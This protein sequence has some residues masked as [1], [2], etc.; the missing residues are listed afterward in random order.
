VNPA[1]QND[2]PDSLALAASRAR[3][4]LVRTALRPF[5]TGSDLSRR[6][7]PWM[8]ARSPDGEG[9]LVW[10]TACCHGDEVGGIVVIQEIFRA[11]RARP[12]KR[13]T[14]RAFPLMNPIGFDQCSRLLPASGED[15]NRSFP[16]DP[17]GTLG[18]R[19]AHFLFGE[20]SRPLPALVLD[21]HNDWIRSVPYSVIDAPCETA[22]SSARETAISA[23]SETDAIAGSLTFSLLSRGIPA[24]TLELGE[25]H[26]VNEQNVALAAGGIWAALEAHGMVSPSE[27]PPFPKPQPPPVPSG[28]PLRYTNRPLATKSGIAR[29]LCHPGQL[30]AAGA[31]LVRVVNAFGRKQEVLHAPAEALVLGHADSSV[32]FP[33]TSLVALAVA[34]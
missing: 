10:I 24:V 11:L 9:P 34:G 7:I 17:T 27:A 2:A 12:L 28:H 16:G 5:L 13:G 30:V 32:V 26:V 21:L 23:A 14:L 3:A 18:Q 20:I 1:M 22:S 25:S 31:P 29:F 15:L 19:I 8:E 4:A 33:G 6:R